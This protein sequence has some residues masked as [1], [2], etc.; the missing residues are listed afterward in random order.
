M[1]SKPRLLGKANNEQQSARTKIIERSLA[2]ERANA[3]VQ[4][5]LKQMCEDFS[6]AASTHSNP[7]LRQGK[8]IDPGC[9][10]NGLKVCLSVVIFFLL[11]TGQMHKSF[12][13]QDMQ[14]IQ[15]FF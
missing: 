6:E 9:A 2:E 5:T 7:P 1:N 11:H 3:L 13:F 15:Q 14:R 4:K 10:V 8:K 12:G